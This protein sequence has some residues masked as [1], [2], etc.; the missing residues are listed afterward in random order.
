MIGMRLGSSQSQANR[1]A[2]LNDLAVTA[3]RNY[4]RLRARGV[5][6]RRTPD[7][8][9]ATFCVE[10]GYALLQQDRDFTR[11]ADELGLR[12]I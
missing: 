7:L 9:I 1:R 8:I 2:R 3:A 5:T 12:L 10:N 11:M 4:R 6:V